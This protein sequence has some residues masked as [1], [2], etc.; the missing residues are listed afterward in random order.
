MKFKSLI[1][2]LFVPLFLSA[3]TVIKTNL[4]TALVAVPHVGFETKIGKKSTFQLDVLA[5]FWKGFNG[6]PQQFVIVIPEYRYYTKSVFE[7]FFVGVHV[8][9][10]AYKM[11]KWNYLNTEKYQEGY[12]ILYGGTVGYQFKISNNFNAEI[13]VGGGS[14]QGYYKGYSMITGARYDGAEHYNISGEIVPYRGG[15]MLVYKLK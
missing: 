6:G 8:G 3:Q 15:V 10:A 4:L 1:I 11:Q 2:L 13:F 12:S 7:G 9:G 14:N 5:S